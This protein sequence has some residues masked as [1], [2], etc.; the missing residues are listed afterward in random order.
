MTLLMRC[1]AAAAALCRHLARPPGGA[2]RLA[3]HV[4]E[5]RDETRARSA[6]MASAAAR[7]ASSPQLR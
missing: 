5:V 7:P 3:R 2:P 1:C 6:A 4:G